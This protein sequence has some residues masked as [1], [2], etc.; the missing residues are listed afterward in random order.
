[1]SLVSATHNTYTYTDSTTFS[2]LKGRE[3][4]GAKHLISE[5][6]VLM[7]FL[8]LYQ[9][10]LYPCSDQSVFQIPCFRFQIPCFY[11]VRINATLPL[12]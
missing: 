4:K 12:M 10:C 6:G 5:T 11:A 2:R 8:A 3:D 9:W 7:W 1:M